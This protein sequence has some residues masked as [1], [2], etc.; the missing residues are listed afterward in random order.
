MQIIK[1]DFCGRE[2]KGAIYY[3]LKARNDDGTCFDYDNYD[4]CDSCLKLLKLVLKN[5]EAK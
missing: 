1:C 4:V 2:H 3:N 5:K